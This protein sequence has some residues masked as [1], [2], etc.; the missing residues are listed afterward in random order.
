[1]GLEAA[2]QQLEKS[3]ERASEAPLVVGLQPIALVDQV[4]RVDW[5]LLNSVPGER[6]GSQRVT[7]KELQ[8][9]LAEVT[10][11]TLPPCGEAAAIRT[12]AGGSVANMIRGLAG[13]FHVSS[14][15][16][17][18]RGD[19]EQGQMFNDSMKM[20]GVHL[21][22]LRVKQGPTGQCVCLVDAE[23][24]R[25]MRPCL[26]DAVRLQ[27]SELSQDDVR[28]AKWIVLNGYG[29]YGEELVERAVDLARKEGVQVA[30][31]LS[32]FEV[33]RNFRPRLMK[34]LAS[35]QIDLCF[36]N[37]DEARELMRG[38]GT[39][40]PEQG[41]AFLAKYCSWAVVMLGSK[42]CIACHKNEIVRISAIDAGDVVDTTGAGD[43]FASGFLFG[44]L[45]QLPLEDCCKIGCCAG[46]AVVRALGGEITKEN[47]RWMHEQLEMQNFT[48]EG[49]GYISNKLSLKK[50]PS[51]LER[52]M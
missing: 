28:G 6:G 47:T 7:A 45:N 26:S 2:L 10:L 15:M 46:A 23:A 32:S 34:L 41:L 52:V 31:D 29:L 19:D 30:M 18:T 11:H 4:A 48:L 12:L 49:A 36:A 24:N 40:D 50:L 1:M 44:M 16:I 13:V 37:E 43:L 33:I 20:S 25:T 8:E 38:A 39:F 27:A 21:D 22:R 17:G 5:S 3:S 51:S 14:A 42:G 35:Q 9:I